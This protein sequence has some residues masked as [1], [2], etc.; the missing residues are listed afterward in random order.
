MYCQDLYL[1]PLPSE[2][3]S[4]PSM[5][6]QASSDM[7]SGLAVAK[8]HEWGMGSTVWETHRELL[9]GDGTAMCLGCG[10][11]HPDLSVR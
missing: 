10:E 9:C 5:P 6:P 4:P 3:V 7:G 1:H 8:G 2:N 11:G